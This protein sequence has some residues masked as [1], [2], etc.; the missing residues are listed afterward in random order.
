MVIFF[1][2]HAIR[3]TVLMCAIG[4]ICFL[5]N[6][7]AKKRKLQPFNSASTDLASKYRT[8]TLCS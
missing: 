7:Y 5:E 8:P 6:Y 4:L 1:T 2:Q 3:L